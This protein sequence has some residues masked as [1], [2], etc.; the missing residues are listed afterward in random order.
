[1][2]IKIFWFLFLFLWIFNSIPNT[3]S[4]TSTL[5]S[6]KNL[7]QEAL[8]FVD[9]ILHFLHIQAIILQSLW[10]TFLKKSTNYFNNLRQYLMPYLSKSR[11]LKVQKLKT[12]NILKHII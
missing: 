4:K 5:Y 7:S 1:M 6:E 12:A 10:S 11:L 3:I 2:K 8:G 9:P